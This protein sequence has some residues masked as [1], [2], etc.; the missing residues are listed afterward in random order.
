MTA[1][2]N[3]VGA[4]DPRFREVAE[5]VVW[6][7]DRIRS[8]GQLPV[9]EAEAAAN[10]LYVAMRPEGKV[11]V[12]LLAL[13]DMDEYPV[14]HCINVA[15]LA[16]G[17]AEVLK[18]EESGVRAIGLAGLLYDIG[19]VRV[20]NELSFKAGELT[21]DER[22]IMMRHPADGAVIILEA[23]GSLDLAAVAAY[24]HHIRVDGSGY[25]AMIYRRA[26][27]QVS[28]LIA[29][30][31]SYH[32]LSCPRPFRAAWPADAITSFL[33]QRS[34]VDYDTEMIAAVTNLV[35]TEGAEV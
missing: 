22:A 29:V 34:G 14:V 15:L 8:G 16:M 4:A 18:L 5:A 32:A 1:T 2:T 3:A 20:P 11:T 26:S 27:H 23:D 33:Q 31:D 13:H 6:I 10:A 9:M 30:C 28:R 24:E 25:P 21:E 35:R 19:M 17:A 7:F 12:P